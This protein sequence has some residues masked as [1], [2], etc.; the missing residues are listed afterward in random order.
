MSPDINLH[1][2]IPQEVKDAAIF[3]GNY[4]KQQGIDNWVLY[5]VSSRKASL[6]AYKMGYDS[7][8]TVAISLAEE[9]NASGVLICGL[10]NSKYKI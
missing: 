10:E 5:D 3:L 2:E 1:H 6:D 9:Y 8:L 4:F 7:G